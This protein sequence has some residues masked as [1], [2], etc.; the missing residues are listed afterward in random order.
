MRRHFFIALALATSLA[1]LLGCGNRR[2]GG[3]FNPATVT[4]L[5]GTIQSV[6][7]MERNGFS[8][9]RIVLATGEQTLRVSLGPQ[10]YLDSQPV[11]LAE[12]EAVTVQAS[13]VEVDG[14]IFYVAAEVIKGDQVLKLRDPDSGRPLWPKRR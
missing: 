10:S 14:K 12:G 13:K 6:D 3:M 8:I 5:K 11:K 9:V 4:T 7:T 2:S 1:L